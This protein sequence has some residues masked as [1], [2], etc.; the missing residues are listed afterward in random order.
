LEPVIQNIDV[1]DIQTQRR[2]EFSILFELEIA[3]L[4]LF[5]NR[6]GNS[7]EFYF[8]Y[9]Q[10]LIYQNQNR[11]IWQEFLGNQSFII[12]THRRKKFGV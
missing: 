8:H 10:R 11:I 2:Q 4:E 5:I 12:H 1:S 7:L 3:R 9:E 6:A